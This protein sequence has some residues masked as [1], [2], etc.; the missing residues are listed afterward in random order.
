MTE[1]IFKSR[2]II[3]FNADLLSNEDLILRRDFNHLLNQMVNFLE[4]HTPNEI[5]QSH[6]ESGRINKE[7]IDQLKKK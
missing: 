3:E 7:I 6:I 5:L 1:N 2:K 4:L